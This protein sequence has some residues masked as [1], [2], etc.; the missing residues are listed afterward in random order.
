[1]PGGSNVPSSAS[2]G[3]SA[4]ASFEKPKPAESIPRDLL[5][6]IRA[7]GVL[8]DRQ[9]ADIKAKV[10]NGDYPRDSVALAEALVRD[11]S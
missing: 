4:V 10:L 2:R 11:K 6:V 8:T 7:S 3:R 1:M 5:P 9:F